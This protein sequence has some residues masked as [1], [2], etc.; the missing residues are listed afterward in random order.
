MFFMTAGFYSVKFYTA[1][2]LE[3]ELII[4]GV[5]IHIYPT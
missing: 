4:R 1:V 3:G 5:T 2:D